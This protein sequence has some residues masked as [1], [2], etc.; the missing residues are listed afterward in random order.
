MA[1][2]PDIE[3]LLQSYVGE[4]VPYTFHPGFVCL[5]YTISLFG[6]GTTLELIRR[7]TSHRGYH[8][9]QVAHAQAVHNLVVGRRWGKG[10]LKLPRTNNISR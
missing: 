9:L 4:L 8:N 3:Q 7:R 2:S 10:G 6:T 1:A 5:S